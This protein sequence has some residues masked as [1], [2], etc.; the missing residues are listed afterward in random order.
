[1]SHSVKVSLASGIVHVCDTGLSQVSFEHLSGVM[2][3]RHTRR[4]LQMLNLPEKG[5]RSAGILKQYP[6]VN[7]KALQTRLISHYG[8]L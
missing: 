3:R 8:R 6:S 2:L 4:F 1:M 5:E 7:S